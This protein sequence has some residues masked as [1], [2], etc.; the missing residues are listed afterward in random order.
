[1]FKPTTFVLG[2]LT[3]IALAPSA[4]AAP[5]FDRGHDTYPTTAQR[6]VGDRNSQPE[7]KV[8]VNPQSRPEV[9]PEIRHEDR[10]DDRYENRR[11]D[12]YRYRQEAERRRE[13]D[14]RREIEIVREREIRERIARERAEREA[15]ARWEAAHHRRH[16]SH[17]Q[18]TYYPPV[19]GHDD[20]HSVYRR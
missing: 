20:Y 17:S 11:G 15:H 18:P 6:P 1:M 16:G 8:I 14:R 19:G 7:I 12:E 5:L 9:R 13:I 3:L 2:L 4:Q 10:R